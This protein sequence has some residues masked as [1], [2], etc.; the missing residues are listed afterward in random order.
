MKEGFDYQKALAR[1]EEIAAKVEDPSTGLED[2]DKYVKESEEL[3]AGCRAYLR[4][5]R[6]KIDRSFEQ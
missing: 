2:I 4:T 3:V 6:E 5:V 1:L